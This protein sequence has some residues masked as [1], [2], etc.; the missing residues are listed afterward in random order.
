[1]RAAFQRLDG[2]PATEL[3]PIANLPRTHMNL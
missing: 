1:M 3:L 2:P